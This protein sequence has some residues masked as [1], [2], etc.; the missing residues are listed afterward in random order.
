MSVMDSPRE[1]FDI[2]A[3][4]EFAM[5]SQNTVDRW[6][7]GGLPYMRTGVPAGKAG[8]AG[9]IVLREDLL[10]WIRS[11][12][13]VAAKAPAPQPKPKVDREKLQKVNRAHKVAPKQW[14]D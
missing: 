7:E 8:P 10:D 12:R 9:I 6:I 5:V 1:V 13:M 4:A 11:H 2:K 14:L 3:A